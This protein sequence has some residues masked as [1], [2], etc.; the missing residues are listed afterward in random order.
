ME[1][2]QPHKGISG[3]LQHAEFSGTIGKAGV[4]LFVLSFVLCAACLV[5]AIRHRRRFVLL[6]CGSIFMA[7]C[8]YVCYD[9]M[10][11]WLNFRIRPIVQ[12][13]R[14]DCQ[15]LMRPAN[16]EEKNSLRRMIDSDAG[17]PQSF[18][19][20]GVRQISIWPG[21]GV[22]LMFIEPNPLGIGSG[23]EFFFVPQNAPAPALYHAPG[24]EVIRQSWF[25]GFYEVMGT[26][27]M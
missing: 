7:I 14:E 26:G 5:L 13:V 19:R 21:E 25:D 15:K 20:L 24:F 1:I 8:G 2:R 11:I 4:C 17:F 10:H 16:G 3:I 6:G 9:F 18:A 27:E 12:A 23:W 22:H